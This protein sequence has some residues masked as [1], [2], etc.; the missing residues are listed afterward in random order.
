MNKF[1]LIK[2]W[3]PSIENGTTDLVFKIIP[4]NTGHSVLC[5]VCFDNYATFHFSCRLFI[6]RFYQRQCQLNLRHEFNDNSPE[7][8]FMQIYDLA[9]Y[10][11]IMICIDQMTYSFLKLI[12]KL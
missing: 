12:Q 6:N 2:W 1:Y 7:D 11:Q 3:K 4:N 9:I 8:G 10:Y 5:L